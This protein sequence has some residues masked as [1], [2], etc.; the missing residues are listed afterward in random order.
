MPE[1]DTIH[2]TARALH[3]L[4]GQPVSV[5]A[6]HPRAR[7]TGVAERL[8]GRT[9]HAVEARGKNLLLR[10]DGG[11]VLRSHLGMTGRW[12][13]LSGSAP[14]PGRPWLVLRGAREQAV[15]RGGARLELGARVT[16]RLGPDVLADEPDL[17][18]MIANLRSADRTRDIGDLLLDQRLVGGIGN[19]WRSEALWDGRVDPWIPAGELTDAQLAAVLTAATRLMRESTEGAPGQRRVYRRAGRPCPRCGVPVS[20]RPQGDGARMVYWCPG[21]QTG[22]EPPVA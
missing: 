13:V 7:A 19:I 5:E 16:A 8:D 15:L 12:R 4:V 10:F 3:A 22:K 20:A 1:G 6:I 21:C 9:L 18:R 17:E 11:L 2:R 14:V